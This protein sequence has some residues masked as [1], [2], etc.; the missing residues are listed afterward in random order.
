V[1]DDLAAD[2]ALVL[3]VEVLERLAGREAGRADACLPA[4]ALARGDLPLETGDEVGRMIPALRPGP[5]GEPPGRVEQG[6]CLEG[7]AEVREVGGRPDAHEG[8]PRRRS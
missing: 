6:G 2:G 5:L 1:S 8:S 3:E 7:S 4:M